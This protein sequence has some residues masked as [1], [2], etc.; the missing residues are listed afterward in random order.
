MSSPAKSPKKSS[1]TKKH[2]PH[3]KSPTKSHKRSPS[4]R[5]LDL[6]RQNPIAS[7]VGNHLNKPVRNVAKL[8]ED[9][10]P[11]GKL[12]QAGI[13]K[14]EHNLQKLA[15]FT[16]SI[17]NAKKAYNTRQT[18][19]QKVIVRLLKEADLLVGDI[20][21]FDR[22]IDR[23]RLLSRLTELQR[24]GVNESRLEQYRNI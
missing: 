2:S 17:Q 10:A 23:V 19:K 11:N 15:M 13:L 12:S 24:L 9:S 18:K 7:I 5:M 16:K 14:R 21:Q 8:V 6:L 3:K 22:P 4:K 20:F 1:G